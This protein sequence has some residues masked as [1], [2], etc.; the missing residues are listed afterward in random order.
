MNNI[1]RIIDV[2][3]NRAAEGLRVVEEVCRFVLED[4]KLT[5]TMKKLRD[6]VSRVIGISGY[7]W[8]GYR[9]IRIPGKLLKERR[10]LNDVGR[11]MY[12]KAEGKR[13]NVE[14]VF[15]ANMKRVQEAVRCLEE[16]SK[17]LDPRLGKKFK[18]IR[19]K[20]YALEKKLI[21]KLCG[22]NDPGASKCL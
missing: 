2:N 4:K 8:E 21:E 19:F 10:A 7:Q 5:L 14:S 12:T 16:F 15:R 1:Y 18:R 3:L 13:A 9:G 20:L 22:C 11:E 17:L 6:Q